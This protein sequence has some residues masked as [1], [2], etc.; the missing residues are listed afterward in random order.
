M[1]SDTNTTKSPLPVLSEDMVS[2]S[3]SNPVFTIESA[4]PVF[5]ADRAF[6]EINLPKQNI[7]NFSRHASPAPSTSISDH[8]GIEEFLAN[9]RMNNKF[10]RPSSVLSDISM[11]SSQAQPNTSEPLLSW[12]TNEIFSQVAIFRPETSP[13]EVDAL[14]SQET[15]LLACAITLKA[16]HST[17]ANINTMETKMTKVHTSVNKVSNDVATVSNRV[18][19]VSHTIATSSKSNKS[20]ASAVAKDLPTPPKS[21]KPNTIPKP[22]NKPNLTNTKNMMSKP[23]STTTTPSGKEQLPALSISQR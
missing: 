13:E 10:S 23:V 21:S 7:D 1:A 22:S 20:Y 11:T 8:L 18:N 6:L 5:S 12:V 17:K 9:Q 15:L 16:L 2:A 4:N 14:T 3:T 19:A